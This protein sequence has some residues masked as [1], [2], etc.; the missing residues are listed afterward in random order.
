MVSP[1]RG[2]NRPNLNP[3]SSFKQESRTTA[4]KNKLS[5]LF[6]SA[7]F[8]CP[9]DQVHPIM[10]CD[11]AVNSLNFTS[12]E[13]PT[14]EGVCVTEATTIAPTTEGVVEPSD[15]PV[16]EPAEEPAEEPVEE[17]LE[18]PVEEPVEQPVEQ[19]S[20]WWVHHKTALIPLSAPPHFKKNK[21]M[22]VCQNHVS[23]DLFHYSSFFAFW[24]EKK[25][26]RTPKEMIRTCAAQKNTLSPLNIFSVFW[27]GYSGA[28][29][30]ILM[31]KFNRFVCQYSGSSPISP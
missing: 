12:L 1:H 19:P 18:E 22:F 9:S 31:S 17:P 7:R 8:Y 29:P 20:G 5:E 24:M 25:M 3:W 27:F 16:G 4:L 2:L 15:E 13:K 21:D 28:L 6:W 26:K 30:Y 14:G 23:L 11:D 10:L